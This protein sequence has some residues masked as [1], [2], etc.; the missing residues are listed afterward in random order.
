MSSAFGTK[1][2]LRLRIF[3]F[4]CLIALGGVAIFLGATAFGYWR[5]KDPGAF[6]AFVA[7]GAIAA[8]GLVGMV[9]WIW[10]L[11]DE[12]VAK[13]LSSLAS[14]I[15]ARVHAEV[16]S[17]I[18]HEAAQY[19]GD[20]APAASEIARDLTKTRTALEEAV[21]RETDQ[22]TRE[23]SWLAAI[24]RDFPA[25]VL[26]CNGDHKIM[27]YNMQSVS[28]L[29][30][31]GALGLDR[32]L[33]E[34]LRPEPL[35]DALDRL[36]RAKRSDQ[37]AEILCTSK[38][39]GRV[40]KGQLRLLG[41]A[42]ESDPKKGGYILILH[43]VTEDLQ[44]HAARDYLLRDLVEMIRRPAA[45]LRTSLA[46]LQS[47][48][49]FS[50]AQ[51]ER[52]QS[53]LD[54]EAEA[55]VS[56]IDKFVTRFDATETTWWPMSDIA[57]GDIVA[58]LQAQLAAQGLEIQAKTAPLMLYCGGFAL[59][60]LL[61]GLAERL[62]RSRT[63][64]DLALS[65][66]PEGEGATIDL[67]WQGQVLPVETLETWLEE[68]LGASYDCYTL[69]DAVEV[70]RTEIWPERLPEG[71][72]HLRLPL[73]TASSEQTGEPLPIR[74]EFYDFELLGRLG[75]HLDDD[76]PLRDLTY[77]VFDTETTGLEPAAG[78][79]IVQIAGVRVVNGRIMSG[80]NFDVLVNPERSIPVSSTKIHGITEAMVTDAPTID[81]VCGDF[82]SF[83]SGAVL[84]AHNAPFD[85]AFL[86]RHATRLSIDFDHP[87]LDTVLLSAI[88]FG[89][90]ADH[91]LDAL[92]E[93]LDIEI[94]ST[95][96]HTALGDA[97]A[98]A[99]ALI[100]LLPMLEARG[101]ETLKQAISE[102]DNY[103]RIVKAAH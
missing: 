96:R 11:F 90:D 1:L 19:L 102:F 49:T 101:I 3:L 48:G 16:Q 79:E 47:P 81:S 82:H 43:D 89:H 65:I 31:T 33:F 50:T 69:R 66:Q 83:C 74:P 5:L 9:A 32:A 80:E 4:F 18:D 41:S 58:G 55:L 73:R 7:A 70:H 46:I 84:V 12:N 51:R 99:L 53:V 85:M 20:I 63:G 103:R 68:P 97:K 25:G 62:G 6:D 28:L 21:K 8:F 88:V 91:S 59:I 34:L 2:S 60:Q 37:A 52:L 56:I 13:P 86:R 54:K 67:S 44:V 24:L 64:T 30:Q 40:F 57:A 61:A 75:A 15:R 77:V 71:R 14:E 36:R 27:L 93:R 94:L 45:N 26:L 100:K 38:S 29:Q 95:E 35:L 78:D 42:R 98:T 72:A 39:G 23:K 76:R 17:E 92:A 10:L 22:I 87:I